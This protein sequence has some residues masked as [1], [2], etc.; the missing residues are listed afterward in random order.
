[1]RRPLAIALQHEDGAPPGLLEPWAQDRGVHLRTVRVD[2]GEQLP[3]PE[4]VDFAVVLGATPSVF[5]PEVSWVPG[6]LRWIAAADAAGV[7]LLGVCFGGQAIAAAL[8][9]Q[10]RAAPE[11][12]VG[13]IEIDRDGAG[14][15][16]G[17]WLSWHRDV[18]DPP[19]GARVTA[20]SAVGV[21]A[22]ELGPHLGLQFHPEVTVDIVAGWVRDS[23]EELRGIGVDGDELLEQ[24]RRH[25]ELAGAQ[26]FALFDAFISGLA[27]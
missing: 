13:W 19:P 22:Y 14:F 21:H 1:M 6:E 16:G 26:A 11:P 9:G 5:D 7:P 27:R 3:D 24:C 10:V 20:R 8:G 15:A 12:E 23:P 18:I 2:L 4:Q 25:A 17:P